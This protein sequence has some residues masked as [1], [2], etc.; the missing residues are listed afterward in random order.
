M[1]RIERVYRAT[2]YYDDGNVIRRRFLTK[3]A[4][5]AWAQR[6]RDGYDADPISS[7]VF[8]EPRPAIPPATRVDV[9]DSEP[10]VWPS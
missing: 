3:P 1:I 6:R 4:R 10:I 2:A 5:D 7:S 9:E 8:D